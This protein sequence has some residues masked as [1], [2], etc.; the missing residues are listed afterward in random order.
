MSARRLALVVTLV[1]VWFATTAA[2]A[3]PLP[4]PSA[5]SALSE[6]DVTAIYEQAL[7]F[8]R[9]PWNQSRWLDVRL[10][11]RSAGDTLERRLDPA[12]ASRLVERLGK[13]FCLLDAPE[14]CRKDR[15]AELRVSDLVVERPDRVRVTVAC[16]LVWPGFTMDNG[17]QAFV[18]ARGARGWRIEDRSGAAT[19]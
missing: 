17:A 14:R 18:I 8:Y 10:M 3:A 2:H 4:A 19:P 1:A 6:T 7:R 9:P 11:R 16:R 5:E 13:G 12:L 15:G